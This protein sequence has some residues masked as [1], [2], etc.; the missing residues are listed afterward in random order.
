M[1]YYMG[2]YGNK[3][4]LILEKKKF[5]REKYCGTDTLLPLHIR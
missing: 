2:K 1:G 5:P 4:V 3:R